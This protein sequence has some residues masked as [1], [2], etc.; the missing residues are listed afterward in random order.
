MGLRVALADGGRDLRHDPDRLWARPSAPLRSRTQRH[1]PSDRDHAGD[2]RDRTCDRQ[3]AVRALGAFHAP[4]MGHRSRAVALALLWHSATI[5]R[6]GSALTRCGDEQQGR[7]W[8]APVGE[9]FVPSS[10]DQAGKRDGQ[11]RDRLANPDWYRAVIGWNQR[12]TADGLQLA[13][14]DLANLRS[15]VGLA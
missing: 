12:S 9:I 8:S 14:R 7:R 5:L 11:D 15:L 10:L 2:H 1:G 3:N 4:T 13:I 6:S